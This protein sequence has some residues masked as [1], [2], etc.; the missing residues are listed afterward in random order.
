MGLI[1]LRSHVIAIGQINREIA[2]HARKRQKTGKWQWTWEYSSVYGI[3]SHYAFPLERIY[4]SVGIR[5]SKFKYGKHYFDRMICRLIVKTNTTGKTPST[6]LHKFH[7]SM[8]P[9]NVSF[10]LHKCVAH[11]TCHRSTNHPTFARNRFY[12]QLARSTAWIDS[13][14]NTF[15]HLDPPVPF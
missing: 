4:V 13:M 8:S 1:V 15:Y 5:S 9:F 11:M 2:T 7:D 6:V 12:M 10:Y 14:S 3:D